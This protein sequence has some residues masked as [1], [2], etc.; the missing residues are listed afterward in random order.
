MSETKQTKRT[1]LFV[2][3]YAQTKPKPSESY[4]KD[5]RNHH[6][7]SCEG[8]GGWM[9]QLVNA[10]KLTPLGCF[11]CNGWGWVNEANLSCIHEFELTQNL[12]R[13]YNQYTCKQC[14]QKRNIDSSD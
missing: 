8:H 1:K 13:C 7:P 14:G 9:T 10:N 11:Q 3:Q 2:E 4:S 6:C 12:G 5:N